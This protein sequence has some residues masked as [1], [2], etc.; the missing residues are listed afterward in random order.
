MP[1]GDSLPCR[2]L[3]LSDSGAKLRPWWKGWLP[4]AFELW[5]A[6]TGMRRMAMICWIN[7]RAPASV[8]EE[9][10]SSWRLL[11]S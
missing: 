7:S 11:R 5:D 1:G 8:E 6:F 2:I 4:D 10:E 9:P 3:D